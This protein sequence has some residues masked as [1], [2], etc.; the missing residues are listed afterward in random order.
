MAAD[1]ERP[2]TEWVVLGLLAEA[3]THGFAIARLLAPGGEVRPARMLY[4]RGDFFSTLGVNA[5]SGR[6]FT[7]EDDQRGCGAPGIIISHDFWRREYGEDAN[8]IGRKL[9]FADHSFEIIGVTP[10]NFFGMEV[11]RSFDLSLPVCAIPLVR[12]NNNFLSGTIWWLTVAGRL[13]PGWTVDQATAHVQSISPDLF[14]VALP[15]DYPPASVNDY[16]ASKL[17][18]VPAGKGI[19]QLREKYEQSLWLLLAIAGLVGCLREP[20]KPIA[21]ARE[22]KGT[23]DCSKTGVGRFARTSD[24]AIIG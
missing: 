22:R 24:P 2:L 15:A 18:A 10:A 8:V 11:G 17:T 13:K 21:R 19:S 1:R 6:L 9:A 16:L 4:V 20:G 23:R 7:S 14:Q 3:P 12:G 5:A